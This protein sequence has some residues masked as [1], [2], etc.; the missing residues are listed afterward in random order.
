M[1]RTC[2]TLHPILSFAV[3]L[4]PSAVQL[5]LSTPPPCHP[6]SI[7]AWPPY[8]VLVDF[9]NTSFIALH[10]TTLC[11]TLH[12]SLV[13]P[14]PRIW[15]GPSSA[16]SPSPLSLFQLVL[17]LRL[18]LL[19][20]LVKRFPHF[21][22]SLTSMFPCSVILKTSGAVTSTLGRGVV[23]QRQAMTIISHA[24]PPLLSYVKDKQGQPCLTRYLQ[25]YHDLNG[26]KNPYHS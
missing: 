26:A 9:L 23:Q 16:P 18:P 2:P 1:V 22:C 19:A 4:V 3:L 13:S 14:F 24:L 20:L 11:F 8:P 25:S 7:L 21:L 15:A 12:S 6:P 5:E 10:P 17:H